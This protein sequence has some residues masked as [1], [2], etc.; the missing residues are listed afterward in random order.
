MLSQTNRL[1]LVEQVAMQIQQL[2]ES[3]RW[4]VGMRIPAEPELMEQLSVSRNTLREA[5][6][7]LTYAGLLK[8]RQGDGTYVR[9][10]S[11]LGS[12]IGQIVR[13]TE[14]Q[15]TMEVR[16]ALDRE[17]A[18]LAAQRREED[19]LALLR[20]CLDAC[21]KAIE[22]RDFEAYAEWDVRF[23]KG[24]ITASGNGLLSELYNHI[25]DALETIIRQ[26]IDYDNWD[27]YLHSHEQ[28]YN[29]IASGDSNRAA[30]AVEIYISKAKEGI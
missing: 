29:A 11:I 2:I 24:V 18:C 3:G 23:H 13:Q 28:L 21:A 16:H 30:E 8:T 7:A 20:R 15:E 10:S 9:A 25:T 17:A 26:T 27:G 6:R 19:D 4:P 5:I 22:E 1:T 14:L 12:V